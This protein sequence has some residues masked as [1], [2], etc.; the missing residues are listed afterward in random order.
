LCPRFPL[1]YLCTLFHI[2]ISPRTSVCAVRTL[3]C[4][5]APASNDID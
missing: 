4:F 3:S 2:P 5:C 1:P